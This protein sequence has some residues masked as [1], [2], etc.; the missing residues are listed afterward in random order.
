MEPLFFILEFDNVFNALSILLLFLIIINYI[1][2]IKIK[3]VQKKKLDKLETLIKQLKS[4][5]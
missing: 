3:R 4:N 1:Y 5:N 2:S